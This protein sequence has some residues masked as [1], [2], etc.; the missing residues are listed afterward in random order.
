[1]L[2]RLCLTD[3]QRQLVL[4]SDPSGLEHRARL[5]QQLGLLI[6]IKAI[7]SCVPSAEDDHPRPTW[8]SIGNL[9]MAANVFVTGKDYR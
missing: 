7:L 2:E 3:E 5:F 8:L 9:A 6:A 4:K 1:M